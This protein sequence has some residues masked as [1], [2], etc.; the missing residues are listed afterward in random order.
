[1][2]TILRANRIMSL[3]RRFLDGVPNDVGIDVHQRLVEVIDEEEP[4]TIST[5]SRDIGRPVSRRATGRAQDARNGS[6]P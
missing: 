2:R 1:M 5:F 4:R 3:P 6:V